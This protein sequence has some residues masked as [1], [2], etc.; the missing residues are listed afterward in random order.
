MLIWF[1]AAN[2]LGAM[3]YVIV[4]ARRGEEAGATVFFI[5][6]PGLGFL[7]YFLP[8]IFWRLTGSD[9]MDD[10][11]TILTKSFRVEK[12]PE[13]PKVSE[14]L[15]VVS[16]EDAVAVSRNE[17]K[18][19]LLL[20]QMKKD[21]KKNY[22]VFMAAER[23]TD[24]ETVHYVAATKMEI[25]RLLQ[26]QWMDCRKDYEKDTN[27][28][29]KYHAVCEAL[30]DMLGSGVF[31]VLEQ[32]SYRKHLCDIIQRKI[33]EEEGVVSLKE[34]EEYLDALVALGRYADAEHIWQEKMNRMR[35]EAAYQKMLKMF[36]QAGERQKFEDCLDDLSRNRQIR[37]SAQGLE[38]L[39]YWRN[40]LSKAAR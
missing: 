27:D 16:V 30:T 24:S 34:Y 17:A 15:N 20:N 21:L 2:F 28:A 14:A 31:S 36:Y 8:K 6:L 33:T 18:R 22:K 38:Q 39:R 19:K 32:S 4:K 29:E 12:L 7:I 40:R 13:R 3:L 10:R 23:D 37:L 1:V 9:E 35:S 26:Q 5:F 25:Y 11:D